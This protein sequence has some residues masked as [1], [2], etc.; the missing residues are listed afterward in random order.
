MI[1]LVDQY[2]GTHAP[3]RYPVGDNFVIPGY[4]P[5]AGAGQPFTDFDLAVAAYFIAA[6]T[7]GFGYGHMYHLFLVPGQAVCFD[8]TFSVCYS[9]DNPDTWI[10]CAYHGS[11]Q[12]TAGNLALYTVEP[13]QNVSG[14]NVRPGT[15]N[16]QLAD[17][18]NDVLSHETIETITD[19]E[20][21]GWWNT[22]NLGLY[23]EEIA[24]ECI[25]LFFTAND[26]FG[27][28]NLVRLNGK[29][30]AIQPEYSNSQHACS[31]SAGGD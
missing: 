17:S 14:C 10:F 21:T 22:T 23:G 12:D 13:F 30:Y 29:S 18:T 8:N 9:P 7:G 31:T 2:V 5:S 16:G 11:I 19:P 6:Q 26:V 4:D 1:H 3:G 27:D 28:P 15:P 20:G 24:D 25:F